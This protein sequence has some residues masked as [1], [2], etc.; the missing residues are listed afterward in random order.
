[1]TAETNETMA[2]AFWTFSTGL[3][4]APG[5]EAHMLALQD[6]H[7]LDVNLALF[8]LFAAHVR[9]PLDYAAIEAMR[10]SGLAWGRG[11]VAP[12]RQA[13]RAMKPRASESE[14]AA[15]LRNE[16]KTIELAAEK[17]MQTALAHLLVAM[18]VGVLDHKPRDLAV[19]HFADWLR[20]EGIEGNGAQVIVAALIDA[21]FPS[22]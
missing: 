13:R 22:A 1:M 5:V 16:V 14:I 21:A 20:A 15:G 2:E 9:R 6:E 10:A 12:L 4:A 3:Y 19:A 7:G 8:C 18:P 11:V 17:A